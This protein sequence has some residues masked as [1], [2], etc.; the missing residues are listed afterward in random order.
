MTGVEMVTGFWAGATSTAG[1]E[2]RRPKGAVI[3][4]AQFACAPEMLLHREVEAI[5]PALTEWATLPDG[6]IRRLCLTW[7]LRIQPNSESGFANI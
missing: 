1:T 5:V 4:A 7:G 2:R 6:S 3:K